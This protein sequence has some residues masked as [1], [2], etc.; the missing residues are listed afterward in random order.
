MIYEILFRVLH[1]FLISIIPSM[2]HNLHSSITDFVKDQ[3]ITASF[4]AQLKKKILTILPPK[5]IFKCSC[6]F[7]Y[8]CTI[9][10]I[11][12]WWKL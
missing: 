7:M 10:H 11:C 3:Q 2:L 5:F 6:V 8:I 12:Y 9:C 1:S 4:K